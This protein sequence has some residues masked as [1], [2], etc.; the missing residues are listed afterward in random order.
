MRIRATLLEMASSEI[1]SI[2]DQDEYKKIRMFDP[3]PLFRAYVVGHEGESTGRISTD[4]FSFVKVVKRWYRSAIEKLKDTIRVGVQLF[5]GHG[6]TNETEGRAPIGYVVGKALRELKDGLSAVIVAYIKPEFRS[7]NLDVASIEADI[8]L[9]DDDGM[10]SAEVESVSGIALGSS[11]AEIP[12]FP[13]A[14][15]LGYVQEFSDKYRFQGGNETMATLSEVK[16]AVQEGKFQPTDLYDREV[17]FADP[18]IKEHVQEKIKNARGYDIRKFEDLT[19]QRADFEKKLQEATE[20][21]NEKNE[22]IKT[23]KTESAKSKTSSLFDEAKKTRK[24]DDKQTKFVEKRLPKFSPED[25][26]KIGD[27]FEKFMDATLDDYD[28][29]AEVFGQKK[30]DGKGTGEGEGEGGDGGDSPADSGDPLAD[31]PFID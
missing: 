1:M 3:K 29:V 27:E 15:L 14:T 24:L 11:D 6:F 22:E 30:P 25:P 5:H 20:Q 12:G 18:A 2:V 13:G 16:Q 31:N 7:M 21:L 9:K 28:D 26:E 23:L 19:E 17:L 4:G 8:V 10:Y